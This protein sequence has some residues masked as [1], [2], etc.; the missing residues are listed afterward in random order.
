[1]SGDRD[2]MTGGAGDETGGAGNETTS[3]ERR[4]AEILER[5]R[6]S[7]GYVDASNT[8]AITGSTILIGA[9]SG[10][11]GA[12]G[13]LLIDQGS[14]GLLPAGVLFGVGMA[15][16]A[17]DRAIDPGRGLVWGLGIG[18][19]VWGFGLGFVQ[20][21]PS[22]LWSI[23]VPS[24]EGAFPS[25]VRLLL[26]FGAPV[27][28]SIGLCQSWRVV[29]D[30]DPIDVPRAIVVGSVAGIVGGWAFSAWMAQ[31]GMFPL[32]AELVGAATPEIGRIVHF[33]IAVVIGAT[34]GVLFQ[35]DARG[36]GSSLTWGMAY[37][38]FWWMLGGFTLFPFLL[39]SP[40][41]WTVGAANE[42]LGSFVGHVIYGLL[43]GLVYSLLDKGWL[44]LFH[45]SDPLNRTVSG[46]GIRTLQAAGWGALASLAGGLLFGI[47]MWTTGELPRVAEL[48]GRSSAASGFAVHMGISAIVGI[49]YGKLFRYESPDFGSAVAWG[50]VYGLIWWFVGALTLFPLL[51]GGSF[52]WEPAAMAAALPSLFGHL[53][54]GAATGGTFY[55]LERRQR[56]WGRLDPRIAEWEADRRR[57]VGTPAPA[58]WA[59]TLGMG[60]FVLAIM[61]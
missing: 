43:L 42:Q 58:V 9:I 2:Q 44:V 47:V 60:V 25:L 33:L 6:H 27:G 5:V 32:I 40:V 28:L 48:V 13:L 1:M 38:M 56:A 21:V 61:L 8:S 3:G 36:H 45:E 15:V 29:S 31:A 59:F 46:P 41:E 54:Y 17:G 39:G 22:V 16:G 53:V 37:G 50:L 18:F 11:A 55:A 49:T 12:I 35:R 51:L 23:D 14:L 20:L 7:L 4:F 10:F 34:F 52:A 24:L 30:R 57:D 26:G 19:L